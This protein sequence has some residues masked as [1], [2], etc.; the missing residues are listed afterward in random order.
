MLWRH[1]RDLNPF[2]KVVVSTEGYF[3]WCERCAMQVNPAY[4]RHIQMQE[5]FSK[6]RLSRNMNLLYK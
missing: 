6:F 2:D 4:P 1:F 5:Y 3:P